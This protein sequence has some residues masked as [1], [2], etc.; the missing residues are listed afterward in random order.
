MNIALVAH[1]GR[2]E[3]LLEWVSYNRSFLMCHKLFATG[4]TAKLIKNIKELK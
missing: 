1:D 4:T 3:E 2:K